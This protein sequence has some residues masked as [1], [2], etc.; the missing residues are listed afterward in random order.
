MET[1]ETDE[2]REDSMERG[3]V[4]AVLEDVIPSASS[5][6]LILPEAKQVDEDVYE[7]DDYSDGDYSDGDADSESMF[8]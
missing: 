5:S 6:S 1:G 7:N 2:I 4:E 3:E 8:P